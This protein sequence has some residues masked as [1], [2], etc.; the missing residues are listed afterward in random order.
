[1]QA[2][3]DF[4]RFQ[5]YHFLEAGDVLAESGYETEG[6]NEANHGIGKLMIALDIASEINKQA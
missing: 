5:L 3:C 4:F 2:V 1:M 6:L